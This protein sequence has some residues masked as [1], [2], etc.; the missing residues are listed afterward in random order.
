MTIGGILEKHFLFRAKIFLLCWQISFILRTSCLSVLFLSTSSAN[1]SLS[2]VYLPSGLFLLVGYTGTSGPLFSIISTTCNSRFTLSHS[3]SS[4]PR[5]P[6][7]FSWVP[8]R[9]THCESSSGSFGALSKFFSMIASYPHPLSSG[10]TCGV[11]VCR[12]KSNMNCFRSL[13]K[14]RH[15]SPPSE[16]VRDD[17]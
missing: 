7:C 14:F 12:V 17:S 2:S 13:C 15:E 4:Q 9:S 11:F 5:I 10:S 8:R 1:R 16:I 6:S 3:P